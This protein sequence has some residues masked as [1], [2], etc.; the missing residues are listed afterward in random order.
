MTVKELKELLTDA[1]DDMTVYIPVESAVVGAFM[2]EEACPAIS[3]P[4][5]FGPP[6][7]PFG[8]EVQE[9]GPRKGFVIAPHSFHPDQ[10]HETPS[11]LN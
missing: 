11:T 1:P 8:Q 5:E 9:D 2:F 7:A 4:V 10:Q 3:G 6:V